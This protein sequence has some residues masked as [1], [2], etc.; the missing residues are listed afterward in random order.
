[1][2]GKNMQN[3]VAQTTMIV[4][5]ETG[6]PRQ[7]VQLKDEAKKI[8]AENHAEKGTVKASIH[9]FRKKTKNDKG[10]ISEVDGLAKLK[11]YHQSYRKAVNVLARYPYSGSFYLAPA[12]VIEDLLK[13]K[14]KFDGM[15]QDV[16]MDWADNDYPDWAKDAP[17]RMGSLFQMTDFPS[18]SDCHKRFRSKLIIL[19]LAEKDQVARITLISPKS[20]EI[21][22]AH[23]DETGKAAVAELHKQIWKDLMAP[24]QQVVTVFEKDKP[25]IYDSLLGNLLEIVNIIP[26][27]KE[28]TA[29]PE[30]ANAA[31]KIKEVFS[32]ITTEDLR[33]NEEARKTALTSAKEM[34]AQFTPFARKF[35]D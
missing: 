21:L 19:P 14:E 6:L 16:W 9:Y 8:E 1:M 28:L 23:A 22:M 13:V 34:V 7:A 30:L 33:K 11:E 27:Y 31:E 10:I 35:I 20:Q 4:A 32:Q 25:K 5:L 18:L 2:K 26:S 17:V 24:L 12:P 3:T 15:G 29:D